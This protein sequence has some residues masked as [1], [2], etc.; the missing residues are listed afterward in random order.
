MLCREIGKAAH[1]SPKALNVM[2]FHA[3]G[4][5]H[6]QLVVKSDVL[7]VFGVHVR[8]GVESLHEAYHRL[9]ALR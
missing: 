7:L 5:S 9:V 6:K 4:A 8:L 3:L 1:F 2:I